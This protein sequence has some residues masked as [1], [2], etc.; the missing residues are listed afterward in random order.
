MGHVHRN[1]A[2]QNTIK[3]FCKA[4]H[5][6]I[7]FHGPAILVNCAYNKT[8]YFFL[9]L[10]LFWI[11]MPMSF[12]DT[13]PLPNRAALPTAPRSAQPAEI[14]YSKLPDKPPY[15]VYLGNIPFDADEEDITAFL[16]NCNVC[17]IVHQIA[18]I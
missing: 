15:T 8:E 6:L 9:L 13:K 5:L 2:L 1:R 4:L 3:W 12:P 10:F 16:R 14:D 18:S 7:A 17:Q 11:D